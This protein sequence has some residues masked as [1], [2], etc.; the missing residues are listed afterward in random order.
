MSKFIEQRRAS[1]KVAIHVFAKATSYSFKR[2]GGQVSRYSPS[3]RLN[4]F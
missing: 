1:E 3:R 2:R 4:S